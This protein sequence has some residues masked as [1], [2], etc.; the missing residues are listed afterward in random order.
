MNKPT[1][2]DDDQPVQPWE[3]LSSELALDEKWFP[4]RKDRVRLP[5]GKIIDDYFVWESPTIVVVVPVTDD[6][7]FIM[8]EQYR[9]A[10]K[11]NEIQF[12]AGG[13]DPGESNEQAALRELEEETGYRAKE[14]IHL[15]TVSV[16]P[17]KVSGPFE[18]YLALGVTP[19]GQRHYDEQEETRVIPMTR[20][21]LVDHLDS[22]DSRPQSTLAA[23]FKVDRYFERHPTLKPR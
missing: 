15:G 1:H 10:I 16:Y 4:V 8:V 23:I 20:T 13:V 18:I 11:K 5:S 7:K 19:D 17:T 21:E 14:V 6:G 22:T 12:P 3:L 2:L 9:H